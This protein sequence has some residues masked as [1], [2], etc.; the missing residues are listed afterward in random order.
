MVG[1]DFSSLDG[2]VEAD[3]TPWDFDTEAR[4]ALESATH[5]VDVGTGGGERLITHLQA[6]T[7]R[8]HIVATEGWADNLPIARA[9]LEPHG[10]EV[11]RYDPEFGD[12]MPLDDASIDL[13]L[14]RHEAVDAAEFA[15]VVRPGGRLL[16]QQVAGDDAH[17]LRAWF[18]GDAA[19]PEV[20]A[21]NIV[22]QLEQCGF[23]IDQVDD[24]TGVL[25]F[26]DVAT[27]VEYMALVPWDVEDFDIDE[28]A[29]AL[30][31]LAEI[32]PIGIS[33]RRFRIIATRR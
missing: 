17:E 15:R 19:Y 13:L 18:G 21:P 6:I 24:W 11:L 14:N 25:R 20:T 27:L 3:H 28:A 16:T 7:K 31:A 1:W 32:R 5:A 8:P 12:E 9:A 33:Q 10:V 30:R 29:D 2:R 23:T 26:R 4:T 22:A